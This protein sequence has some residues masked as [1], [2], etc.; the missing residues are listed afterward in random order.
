MLPFVSAF[1]RRDLL[2][3]TGVAAAAGLTLG[4]CSGPIMPPPV[5]R[6][7]APVVET[8]PALGTITF[9]SNHPGN[10]RETE[11]EIIAAFEKANPGAR[12]ELVDVGES[13]EE[14]AAAFRGARGTS[15]LPD[16]LVVSDVTWFG[17]ALDRQLTPLDDLARTIRLDV[18]DYV[19]TL[20]EDY[21]FGARHYAL[22]Y[23]R[24]TPLFYYDGDLW[25]RAGLPERGPKDWPELRA[26]L[27][28]LAPLT[29][30]PAVP[31]G[32]P[33][34]R[35][36]LDWILANLVWEF[37]GAWS[38]E[39]TPRFTDRHTVEALTFFQ[40]LVTSGLARTGSTVPADFAAGTLACA[41]LSTGELGNIT[42]D[43]RFPVRAAMLPG[44]GN[45]PTGGSG[46]GIPSG[47]DKER[48]V[49]ALKFAAFLTGTRSTVAFSQATG[50]MPVRKSALQHEDERDYLADHP[51]HRIV[52]EQ[53]AQ[54]RTQDNAR[55]FVPGGGALIGAALDEI[56]AGAAVRD[57]TDALQRTMEEL[58]ATE[59]TPRLPT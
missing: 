7:P 47:I 6:S 23:A 18:A 13:Y 33:D 39:W 27:E 21:R 53:L 34:G 58:I 14:V 31:L 36:Y 57:V 44:K 40:E 46:L 59:I 5:P 55:V 19:D 10:S 9:W 41:I 43:A 52:V 56:A 49:N 2:A 32:V 20:Y 54:S 22:P 11:L 25:Q 35:N 28:I 17:L 15:G 12:V 45:S 16:L 30:A 8:G 50:Y 42:R 29:P 48:R 1:T 26:W 24:S 38:T 4:A 3:L 37:G 51:N